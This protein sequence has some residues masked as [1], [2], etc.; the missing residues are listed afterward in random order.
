MSLTVGR[1]AS[2]GA[3]VLL[4]LALTAQGGDAVRYG[5]DG[6]AYLQERSTTEFAVK[7]RDTALLEGGGKQRMSSLGA[8]EVRMLPHQKGGP[9]RIVEVSAVDATARAALLSDG[10]VAT[11]Q[12]VWRRSGKTVPVLSSGGVVVKFKRGTTAAQREAFFSRYGVRIAGEDRLGLKDT[13]VLT[14]TDANAV[15]MIVAAEMFRDPIVE[16]SAA[17]LVCPMKPHQ[18]PADEFFAEQWHLNNTGQGG[19][20]AGA[21]IEVLA[22]WNTTQGADVLVGM[23]DDSCDVTHEDLFSNYSGKGNDISA[24]PNTPDSRDPRPKGIF[25][26]HGTPVM[27]LIVAAPNALG[28]RGVAPLASFSATRGLSEPTTES[29]TA[30]VYSLALTDEVDVHNNS[31]G[32]IDGQPHPIVEAAID[33]AYRTGRV[34]PVDGRARGMV[35]LFATGNDNN[36][37]EDGEDL[38][39]LDSVIG[40]GA[41]NARDIRSFYSNYGLY[42]DLVAPSN[43]FAALPGL[44]STDNEDASGYP[45]NGYNDGGFDGGLPG[46]DAE[47][48]YTLSFGGTSGACPVAAGVAALV[49]SAN[50]LLTADQV[51]SILEHTAERID[52]DNSEAPYRR[53]AQHSI[54][55]GYGR[56]NARRAVEAAVQSVSN[57]NKTWPGVP[58]NVTVNTLV[59]SI[60]WEAPEFDPTLDDDEQ[61]DPNRPGLEAVD[62]L[63]VESTDPDFDFVP[64]DGVCYVYDA[65]N[66]VQIGCQGVTLGELPEGVTAFATK[67]KSFTF[68]APPTGQV[69]YFAL[70]ARNI[71]GRYSFGETG[72]RITSP[73]VTSSGSLGST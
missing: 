34:S 60:R 21:D 35:I 38:S 27:G 29:K 62:Y 36:E 66:D 45:N 39:T 26:S 73:I 58:K 13:Y 25:D 42:I 12:P 18:T 10:N 3:A 53:I 22:A 70:F 40:V 57:G 69:K 52:E 24:E 9:W 6:R 68:T 32:F 50:P 43:D 2:A 71:V 56:I 51:R 59:R 46:L 31:W 63:I 7:F 37:L 15:D 28:V 8:V 54:W 17:D 1:S 49:V 65:A 72:R 55:Y 61:E 19:G 44:V 33:N 67:E 64:T 23:F 11:V 16:W 14:L 20:L 41:S 4:V 48:N 5:R 30:Q 47:G